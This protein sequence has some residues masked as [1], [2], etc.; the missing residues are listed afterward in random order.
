MIK[1]CKICGK[2]FE[3]CSINYKRQEFCS[4]KCQQI[5]SYQNRKGDSYNCKNCGKEFVP[6]AKD[7]T[8]YCSR[9]CA[10]ED[11]RA[12]PK[13][14]VL[15]V[16]VTCGVEFEGRADRKYCTDE[17]KKERARRSQRVYAARVRSEELKPFTCKECGK[18]HTPS[19]GDKSRVYCS[20][21]CARTAG[22]RVGKATRR[23]RARGAGYERVDPLYILHRDGWRCRLCGVKT[24]KKLR[25]TLHDRAPEVDHLQS[26]ADGGTHR[27][28][29]LQCLCR[30][31]NQDKGAKTLGQTML[32][33]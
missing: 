28:E 33:G 13:E 18:T 27:K 24:P 31:C 25:G 1:S 32:W 7:R 20:P 4:R 8:S 12:A 6:K 29:N 30:K 2:E 23:A 10:Y 14:K 9:E 16:C 3:A 17:C 19:Y 26:F 11:K 21:L 5:H 22:R 15:P